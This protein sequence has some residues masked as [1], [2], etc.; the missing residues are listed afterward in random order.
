MK[1][2]EK[3]ETKLFVKEGRGY[4]VTT[5]SFI[6]EQWEDYSKQ[7]NVR[8]NIP[9]KILYSGNSIMLNVTSWVKHWLKINLFWWC[10]LISYNYIKIFRMNVFSYAS[11]ILKMNIRIVFHGLMCFYIPAQYS[12]Q[13]TS[14]LSAV[15]QNGMFLWKMWL[16]RWPHK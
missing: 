12:I 14:V 2:W 8:K 10:I 5:L 7:E 15:E 11:Q 6:H 3:K 9:K 16:Q 4:P 13:R 1:N